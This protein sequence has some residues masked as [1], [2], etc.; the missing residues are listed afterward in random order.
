MYDLYAYVQKC[1]DNNCPIVFNFQGVLYYLA[2]YI[3]TLSLCV[4]CL[5]LVFLLGETNDE[6][7]EDKF[8]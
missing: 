4:I 1:I 6:P 3:V 2:P 8:E 5:P 7:L